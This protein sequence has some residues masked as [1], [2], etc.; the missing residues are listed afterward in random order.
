[1]A[2]KPTPTLEEQMEKLIEKYKKKILIK[3]GDDHHLSIGELRNF[4]R[5]IAT[6][7]R[8]WEKDY[9][10]GVSQWKN[11]GRKWGYWDFFKEEY[12]KK[13]LEAVGEDSVADAG[14][15]D[16]RIKTGVRCYNEAK[17]EIRKRLIRLFV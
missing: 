1:M 13:A 10:M 9:P 6:I 8:K 4:G 11:H 12:R 15:T 16:E 5:A 3:V 2:N 7:C 17:E 14:L